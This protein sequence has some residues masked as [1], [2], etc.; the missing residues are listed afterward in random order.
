MWVDGRYA[1]SNAFEVT[2]TGFLE[3]PATYFH[4]GATVATPNG[5]FPGT[6]VHRLRCHGALLGAR[7]AFGM[8]VRP[9]VGLEAGWSRRSYSEVAHLDDSDPARPL[10]YDLGLAGCAIDDLAFAASAGV[11]WTFDHLSVGF[12]PRVAMLASGGDSTWAVTV[13][14]TV[15]GAGV[16]E[17]NLRSY[18]RANSGGGNSPGSA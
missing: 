15:A 11:E 12:V 5:S 1:L 4:G 17:G 6:L 18:R 14:L 3:P 8:V 7:W 16:S 2:L 9:V 10:D 13:P